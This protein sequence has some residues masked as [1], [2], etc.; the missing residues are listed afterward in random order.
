MCRYLYRCYQHPCIQA[1][2]SEGTRKPPSHSPA[3]SSTALHGKKLCPKQ[4]LQY[5]LLRL[6]RP[7]VPPCKGLPGFFSQIPHLGLKPGGHQAGQGHQNHQPEA[8]SPG[9]TSISYS[10]CKSRFTLSFRWH[11]LL[12]PQAK[13]AL[14][15]L[16]VAWWHSSSSTR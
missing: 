15:E 12:F 11:S 10:N 8:P 16:T 2:G 3:A 7:L 14:A 6:A 9:G 1:Q 13:T 4:E 5:T